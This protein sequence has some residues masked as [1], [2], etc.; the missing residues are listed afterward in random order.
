MRTNTA[1]K[2][3]AIVG[4]KDGQGG[5]K[6]LAL[7][8]DDDV[9]AGRDIVATKHLSY[10][11]FSSV[12]LNRSAELFR[13]RD[14]QACNRAVVGENEHCRVPPVYARAAFID[15]LE[16]GAAADTFMRPER[17]QMALFAADGQALAPLRPPPFEHQAAI[18]CAHPHQKPV[19]FGAVAII[20]LE[21]TLTFHVF[22]PDANRQC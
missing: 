6:H 11:S 14:A 3:V 7:G 12:S 9:E 2:A 22:S 20:R 13:C 8:D 1:F 15:F 16:L 10:E 18:F 19:R 21:R 5:V 17:S 4:F